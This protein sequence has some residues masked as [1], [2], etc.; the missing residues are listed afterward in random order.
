MLAAGSSTRA[1][2][3]NKLSRELNGI[4]LLTHCYNAIKCSNVDHILV[5]TSK[6]NYQQ[7]INLDLPRPEVLLL[8]STSEGLG[9]S[10]AH[11]VK[12]LNKDFSSLIICLSDT[13]LIST[14]HVNM[15]LNSN[16]VSDYSGIHRIYDLNNTPGHPVLFNK[17]FFLELSKLKSDEDPQNLV[18]KNKKL[19]NKIK[20]NNFSPTTDLDTEKDWLIFETS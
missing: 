5:V 7:A 19:I 20:V 13:P 8:N 2:N 12:H 1:K 9:Y 10:I 4:P 17:D 18:I 3:F 16:K 11:G 6:E 15:L 14:F